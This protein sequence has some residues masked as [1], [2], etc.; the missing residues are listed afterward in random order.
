MFRWAR[1]RKGWIQF[2]L[3]WIQH[4]NAHEFCADCARPSGACARLRILRRTAEKSRLNS[5]PLGLIVGDNPFPLADSGGGGANWIKTVANSSGRIS[6]TA[7]HT[8][9]GNRSVEIDV[10]ADAS[11]LEKSF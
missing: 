5:P 6:V 10:E 8:F 7:K 9:L 4:S 11:H 3:E 1:V 2:G